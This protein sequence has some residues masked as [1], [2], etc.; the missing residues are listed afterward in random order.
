MWQSGCW[1]ARPRRRVLSALFV[2]VV[3][4]RDFGG[5]GFEGGLDGLEI[6]E[7]CADNAQRFALDL[8]FDL[9]AE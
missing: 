6:V 9:E 7:F 5:L 2:I 8:A 3:L 4:N 1:R